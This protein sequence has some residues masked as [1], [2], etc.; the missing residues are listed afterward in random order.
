[1]EN[2]R[3]KLIYMATIAYLAK[4]YDDMTKSMRK[5]CEYE[6][7]L[8]DVERELLAIGYKN[9]TTKRASLRALS[10]IEEKEDSKGNKQNVKLINKKLDIV[11][12]EFFSVCN[13]ILSLIDSHLIPSTTNVEST[14]YYYAMKANYFRYMA[15]FG[16][17]AER[18]GAAD[19]SLEAYKIAMETAEGGLSP[20]NMVR[21]GLALNFSIFNYGILKSTESAC[22][23]AKKAYDEAISELD[24]ADKQ[25]YKDTMFI[26]EILRDNIS[27][28]TDELIIDTPQN[29]N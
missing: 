24:G 15:E 7:E 20:T 9:V 25:S 10:S 27:V 21:L 14:V 5:V 11:K 22:K 19:N 8:T 28:W 4:R 17:D 3:G 16:S 1:M 18:E 2:D 23:L 13:D 29:K 6:I 12:H 26:V